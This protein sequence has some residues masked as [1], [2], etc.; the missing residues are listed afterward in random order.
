MKTF[1]MMGIFLSKYSTFEADL[2]DVSGKVFAITGTTSGTG[3]VA[4]QTVAKHNGEVI[5]LNRPSSRSVASLE[6]LKEAVPDGKFVPIDCDLQ[7]FASVLSASKEIKAKYTKLYCLSNNAGIM[8]TPD[9]ITGDGYDKQMQTNHLSHFL[10]TKELLPLLEVSSKEDGD[11]RIVQHSSVAR[12]NTK[13]KTLEEK[14][15]S[16]YEKDGMLGGYDD[17]EIFK[18]P[19]WSRYSQTKLAN[20]VFCQCLHN[21]FSARKDKYKNILSLCAHPGFSMTN[22]ANHIKV[23]FFA[24]ILLTPMIMLSSQSAEDG[25]MGLLKAMM[26]TRDNVEGGILYGPSGMKGYPVAIPPESHETD[27]KSQT[28]LW[29]KSEEAIGATFDI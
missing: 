9:E 24:R 11:A 8:A 1:T 17:S 21:K 29:K 4:A 19:Q 14:Y 26:D 2:P 16:K 3:F 22:L 13:N 6:K 5:L 18:G 7:D 20:S 10:L 15:F 23:S 28:L 12:N 25:T 27:P